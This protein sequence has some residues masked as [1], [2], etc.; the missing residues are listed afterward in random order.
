MGARALVDDARS[1]PG[2]VVL[3]VLLI[4][5][6]PKGFFPQQDT[7]RLTGS[8]QADQSISFQSMQQ[9]LV[10]IG[11]IIQDDPAVETV[12]AFIGGW[13]GGGSTKNTARMFVVLKPLEQRQLSADQVI[14]RLRRQLVQ[15][16]GA[17]TYLQAVQDLRIGGRSARAQY[18]YS[19]QSDDL[20]SLVAWGPRVEQRLRTMPQLA[21]VNSDQQRPRSCS[22]CWRSIAPPRRGSGSARRSSTTRSTTRSDSDKSRSFTRCSTSTTW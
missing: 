5:L 11:R 16:A 15:R 17:P 14:A 13:E 18:Q 9:K 3:N 12:M 10:T 8:I 4:D 1:H 22:R 19:L 6:V 2:N 21:D 20:D 7:G